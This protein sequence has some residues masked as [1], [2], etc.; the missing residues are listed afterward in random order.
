MSQVCFISDLHFGHKNIVKFG[1]STGVRLR[2]GDNYV[3]NMQIII[4]NWN[5]KVTKRDTV[6]VLGDT[7]FSQEGYDALGELAGRKILVRGNHDNKFTTE[8]WLKHFE[9]V[10]GLIKYKG[11]WLSHSPIHPAELRGKLN[12]HGHCHSKSVRDTEGDYDPRYINV[13]CE[14]I[15]ETPLGY[16]E[17]MDGRYYKNRKC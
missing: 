2:S 1:M 17:I 15:G 12:V 14:A 10:E 9:S 16:S 7:A 8:Q 5:K 11:L 6:F 13:C 3:E 4:G